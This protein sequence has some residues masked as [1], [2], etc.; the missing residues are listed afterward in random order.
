MGVQSFASHRR[1]AHVRAEGGTSRPVGQWSDEEI[2]EA[3]VSLGC[4]P[5]PITPTTRSFLERRVESLLRAKS[6]GHWE[7][8]VA[9]EEPRKSAVED[10]ESVENSAPESRKESEDFE[11]YYGVV[12]DSGEL[13]LSPFYTSR[14][15]AIRATRSVAGARFKKFSSQA[16][17]EAF[18]NSPGSGGEIITRPSRSLA[19]SDK[20][21]QYPSLR[22][23]DLCKLRGLIENGDVSGF[24]RSVW[25]NP[26]YLVNCNGDAPEILHVGCRYNALHCAIRAKNLEMCNVHTHIHTHTHTHTHSPTFHTHTLNICI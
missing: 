10:N 25:S 17:A 7:S 24:S 2:R 18:S 20:P 12:A 19:T 16:S 23:Q 22:T 9:A 14:S 21:N 26:R 1:M 13:R 15:E 3:L 6:N 8:Q 4:A 11:G 5:V